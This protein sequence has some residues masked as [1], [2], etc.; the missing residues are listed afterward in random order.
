MGVQT[1]FPRIDVSLNFVLGH[2]LSELMDHIILFHSRGGLD[3]TLHGTREHQT[4]GHKRGLD[5]S[6]EDFI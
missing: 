2:S 1:S 6:D 4:G 5:M 3:L